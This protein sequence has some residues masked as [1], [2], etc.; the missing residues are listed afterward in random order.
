M[1]GIVVGVD[2]SSRSADAVALARGIAA[3]SGAGI[4]LAC[5]Y[6]Y[7]DHPSRP[8]NHADR[9][10]LRADA[11]TTLARMEH[12]LEGIGRSRTAAIADVSPARAL[13]Q[14]AERDAPA[15][16][17]LGS[18]HRSALGHVMA[19]TTAERL[20]HGAPC[21]VALAPH[22]FHTRA[23]QAF[24]TVSVGHDGSEE[25]AAALSA[26]VATAVA[27]GAV[28]RIVRGFPSALAAGSLR[29]PASSG[30]RA[31]GARRV[32]R[33]RGGAD[34][35]RAAP[36]SPASRPASS[37]GSPGGP[38]CC[39]SARAPTARSGPCS[40]GACPDASSARPS[41]P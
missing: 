7:E 3:A 17:V 13:Q 22:G 24:R 35:G 2:G 19:G 21:A 5:A 30:S 33:R 26:A 12:G 27:L 25:S 39:S 37:S 8:A 29:R 9:D 15:L 36:A 38:T 34:R 6:P 11:E 28:L 31:G 20:L 23:E 10:H 41:A 40:S 4:T 32:R 18:S 14:L 1:P 16:I